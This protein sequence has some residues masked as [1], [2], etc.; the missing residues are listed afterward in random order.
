MEINGREKNINPYFYKDVSVAG[1]FASSMN[2]KPRTPECKQ[3]VH[4]D[5]C[6]KNAIGIYLNC[7]LQ[8]IS[9]RQ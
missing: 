8:V 2:T 6:H 1:I 9:C 7:I 3:D 5:R 4:A